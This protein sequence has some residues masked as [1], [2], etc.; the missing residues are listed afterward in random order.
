MTLGSGYAV[1]MA[2][3]LHVV[4]LLVLASLLAACGESGPS[5]RDINLFSVDAEWELGEQLRAEI[6]QQA[7]VVDDPVVDAFVDEIGL[8]MVAQTDLADREWTFT[9]VEDPTVNA[10][11]VPGGHVFVHTGLLQAVQNEAE[12]AGVLAH[13]VAHIEAR[14]STEM[15]TR[16]YGI[17]FVLGL[18]GDEQGDIERIAEDLVT[19]GAVAKFSRDAEREADALAVAH[20][21]GA[22]YPPE[23]IVGF[24]EVLLEER[25]RAP[26]ALD[27]FFATHPLTEERLERARELSQG[28]EPTPPLEPVDG[29]RLADI[30]S[31]L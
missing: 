10:F 27:Q 5:P 22:G 21:A 29:S 2:L 4:A 1:P 25:D 20:L 12:L 15:L 23:G 19:D 26:T 31:R 24:F 6:V 3:R 14:H 9:V 30:Q 18:L 8:D 7:V 16:A 28:L 11:A 17:D 13:E